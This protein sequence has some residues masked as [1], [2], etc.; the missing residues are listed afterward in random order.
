MYTIHRETFDSASQR[1]YIIKLPYILQ[2]CSD[3]SI[4]NAVKSEVVKLSLSEYI[5]DWRRLF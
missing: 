2:I 1:C 4:W 5:L 3:K